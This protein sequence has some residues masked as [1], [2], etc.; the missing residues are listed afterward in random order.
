MIINSRLLLIILAVACVLPMQAQTHGERMRAKVD[1]V[2]TQRQMRTPFDTCYISRPKTKLT[3]KVRGNISGTNIYMNGKS[4]G[5]PMRADVS[6]DHKATLSI[7]ANY[8]GIAA[9]VAVNPAKLAGRYTDYELNLNIYGNRLGLDASYQI[10]N[11]LSGKIT[12]G[13]ETFTLQ[14][15]WIDMKLLNISGYYVFNHRR[16]SFPAAFTQSYIQRRSAGSWLAGFSYQGGTMNT[17]DDLPAKDQQTRIYVGHF[18]IGGG[19]GYNLVVRDKWLFHLSAMPTLVVYSRS[20]ITTNGERHYVKSKFP[21]V[22]LNEHL[23]VVYNFSPRY[24]LGLTGVVS[25]LMKTIDGLDSEQTKW[26]VRLMFGVRL[27]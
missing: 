7:A 8:R 11:T 16:F 3:L 17:T 24:F 19:Y 22:I 27:L 1:S 20:N 6:T 2:L 23:A 21:T 15:G 25:N 26:R 14:R 13:D 10:S 9:G 5:L 4:D 18:A 12:Q